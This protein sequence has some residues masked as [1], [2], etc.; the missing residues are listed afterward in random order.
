M[1]L[2][3]RAVGKRIAFRRRAHCLSYQ[4]VTGRETVVLAEQ[5]TR[6]FDWYKGE[7]SDLYEK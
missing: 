5:Q 6:D 3:Y 4:S 7:L 2:D 1:P